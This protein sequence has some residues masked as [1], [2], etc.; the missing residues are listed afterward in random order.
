M[1][2][3]IGMVVPIE[4]IHIKS[5]HWAHSN[6]RCEIGVGHTKTKYKSNNIYDEFF[7][8]CTVIEHSCRLKESEHIATTRA[9]HH[10]LFFAFHMK[11]VKSVETER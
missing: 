6:T 2:Y 10:S 11:I 7:V 3:I 9:Q 8:W 4:K 1:R 5:V